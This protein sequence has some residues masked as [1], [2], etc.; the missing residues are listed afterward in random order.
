MYSS[1]AGVIDA[2]QTLNCSAPAKRFPTTV[3]HSARSS[4]G[5]PI[6]RALLGVPAGR[7][8]T[9]SSPPPPHTLVNGHSATVAPKLLPPALPGSPGLA[10]DVQRM[11]GWGLSPPQAAASPRQ[12]A[13]RSQAASF[14]AAHSASS[15]YFN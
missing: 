10:K 12:R 4:V 13:P 7:G 9:R 14:P 8:T 1:L 3:Q 5:I 2:Q 6:P 15:F 11:D